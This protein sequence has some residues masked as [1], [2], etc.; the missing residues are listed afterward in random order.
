MTTQPPAPLAELAD[1][2]ATARGAAIVV[3]AR[4]PDG[5]R[6]PKSRL[7]RVLPSEHDRRTLYAA[8][9]ADM[10]AMSRSIE[11]ATV[12]VAYTPDGGAGGFDRIGVTN[13]EL[14]PQRDGNLG[15]RER[16]VF[17]DLFHQGYSPVVMIGSDL[18]TLPPAR[19]VEALTLLKADPRRVVLGPAT[20][21]GYYLLGLGVARSAPS[22][23]DLFSDV[24][25]STAS[26]LADTLAA[27][28]RCGRRVTLLDAWYDVD[29]DVDLARLRQELVHAGG[30][31]DRRA[32]RTSAVLSSFDADP[33]RWG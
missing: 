31:A 27:A 11:G 26:T 5:P 10:V 1:A 16:G 9:L 28:T 22:V 6:A 17:E 30:G 15:D 13:Q 4:S 14:V 25:W 21:G 20:D 29:D 2:T 8:F 23:P 12:R 18:P 33:R 7:A 3:M 19:V 24:R 32:P